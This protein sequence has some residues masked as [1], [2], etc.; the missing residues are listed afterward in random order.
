[1][2][3]YNIGR[4]LVI[5]GS[6]QIPGSKAQMPLLARVT[7]GWQIGGIL[8]VHDGLPLTPTFGSGGDPL[9]EKSSDPWDFPNRL[10]GAGCDTA[11]NSRNPN[12]HIKTQCFSVPT[13][14]DMAFW[15]SHC[16]PAP[17]SFGGPLPSGDLRCFNL[18]GSVGRNI[19]RGPGLVNLDTSL[20]K[21]NYFRRIS[22]T[23][24]AQVRFEVFNVLNH[25]NFQLPIITNDN[26][27]TASG[28]LDPNGGVITTTVTTSRQL[29]LALKIIW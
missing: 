21:N 27:F 5:N 18:R 26:I 7:T 3:D 11:V 14:P 15:A 29:Q 17:P 9:G 22:E 20:F 12:N 23:F 19:L 6:W 13:A 2:S 10:T 25:A 16:D 1:V 4:V 28:G 24:N 8:K